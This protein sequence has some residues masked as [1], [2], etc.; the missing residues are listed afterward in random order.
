MKLYAFIFGICY[1]IFSELKRSEVLSLT[2]GHAIQIKST[3]TQTFRQLCSVYNMFSIASSS[4]HRSDVKILFTN[5]KQYV[6]YHWRVVQ[7]CFDQEGDNISG[8]HDKE[9]LCWLGTTNNALDASL[10]EK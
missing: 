6:V 4:V 7:S 1:C 5:V 8:W 3:S 10:L 9:I 2:A